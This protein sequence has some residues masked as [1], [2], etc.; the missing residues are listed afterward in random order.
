MQIA[1][2][3]KSIP[4]PTGIPS[5]DDDHLVDRSGEGNLDPGDEYAVE[6]ALRI[7]E[8]SEGEVALVTMGPENAAAAIRKGL[9][10]G[11]HRGVHVVD[12]P[13]RGSDALVTAR[14][15]AAALGRA[16]FDVV[17][18]G[19]ESTDGSTGTVPMTVAELLG[20]PSLTFARAVSIESDHVR[21]ERITDAGFDVVESSLPTLVS[22]TGSAAEPRYP[23]L[24][25]IMSAKTKRVETLSLA[26]L[27]ISDEDATPAQ[28][29]QSVVRAPEKGT[30]EVIGADDGAAERI[31]DLLAEAKVL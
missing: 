7:V 24:K 10:M 6:A 4:D 19:V 17:L 11:A 23:T 28:T 31:A 16:P 20:I 21:I 9:S 2:L 29:V 26:E 30:G 8:A 15:L 18:T 1:V 25:G 22:V 13:L 5:L 14:V 12:E 3:V 27:G